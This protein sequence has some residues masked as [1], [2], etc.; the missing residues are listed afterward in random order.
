MV[1]FNKVTKTYGDVTALKDVSFEVKEGEFVFLMGPSGAGKTTILKLILKEILPDSGEIRVGGVDA[2]KVSEKDL[3]GFRQKVGC[4]FQDFKLLNERTTYENI[5]IALAVLGVPEP[6]WKERI[7][8][9]LK[10]V[11]LSDRKN[12]F[13]SQLSGGEIQRASLARALVVN[14]NLILA[15]E[16]TGNLDWEKADEIMAVLEKINKEGK[17]VIVATHNKEVVNKMK[18][19]IIKLSN[20]KIIKE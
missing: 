1:K 17:T 12:L 3:P 18:K 10:M 13:P 14:P 11:G 19:R 15:D 20:G 6:K 8:K 2:A 7:E 16:P 5:E 9:I 4:V